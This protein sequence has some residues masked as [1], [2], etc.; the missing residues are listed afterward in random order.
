MNFFSY[1][2]AFKQLYQEIKIQRRYNDLFLLP[3]TRSLARRYN[4]QFSDEQLKKIKF[5]YGLFIPAVLCASY[6]RLY[7]ESFSDEE[8]K[9]AA[10][11]GILTPVGDDLF[12]IDKVDETEI[13]NIT[14]APATSSV[15]SFAAL[16][17][18]EIQTFLLQ[19]VPYKD[20][21][22]EAAKHVFEIQIETKKQ[23]L[24]TISDEEL[25]RI[26]FAKGGYSV[27]IY[28]SILNNKAT[29]AMMSALFNIGGLMQLTNDV[30]DMRKDLRD[31]IVTI[32]N[33]CTDFGAL[34]KY[35]LQKVKFTNNSIY[36]LPFPKK[37]KEEFSI[38]MNFIISR[39]LV[40]LDQMISVENKRGR[41]LDF[42]Q[43][44]RKELICD[45]QKPFNV[46]RW[47]LYIYRLP[48]LK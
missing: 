35:F 8:R 27:I 30:F 7:Q 25:E 21:Y 3:Y 22:L 48:K 24:F 19:D 18:K 1:T 2:R 39:G 46:L 45:M 36:T 47:L 16:V 13:R 44:T 34:K 10:L 29:T 38:I 37:N 11:F 9:R 42:K 32:P 4:G 43:L 5:Y 14:Y 12:D 41:P 15:T 23:T 17:A 33:R 20:D 26:T 28:H 6:K 40:A 31:G